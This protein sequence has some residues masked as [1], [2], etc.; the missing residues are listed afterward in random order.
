M[1]DEYDFDSGS[2]A[3]SGLVDC[4]AFNPREDVKFRY[5]F[6]G[7]TEELCASKDMDISELV[8]YFR[9]KFGV[10]DEDDFSLLFTGNGKP[11]NIVGYHGKIFD[12]LGNRFLLKAYFSKAEAATEELTERELF[13]RI[14]EDL[15]N[16]PNERELQS[17]SQGLPTPLRVLV[18]GLHPEFTYAQ[19]YEILESIG[20]AIFELLDIRGLKAMVRV[21][22]KNS[23]SRKL[24]TR[25]E[26]FLRER[27]IADDEEIE[28][29]RRDL[30][31]SLEVTN[32]Q[33]QFDEEELI[34]TLGGREEYERQ[35]RAMERFGR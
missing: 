19:I 3:E 15:M 8:D 30:E 18:R 16:E 23:S 31:T 13:D 7:V 29:L 5:T 4:G 10:D 25:L 22:I 21:L 2:E 27:R 14:M 17:M 32:I 26:M 12:V 35:V 33:R 9:D 24:V 1:E 11:V 28:S 6:E 20:A 34:A